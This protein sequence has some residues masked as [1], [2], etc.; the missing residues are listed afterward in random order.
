VALVTETEDGTLRFEHKATLVTRWGGCGCL[1]VSLLMALFVPIFWLAGR[2][3]TLHC[4]RATASCTV[5]NRAEGRRPSEAQTDVTFPISAFKG[6]KSSRYHYANRSSSGDRR[7]VELT[8]EGQ[9]GDK[10]TLCDEPDEPA[11]A[12]TQRSV[13]VALVA[14]LADPKAAPVVDVRCEVERVDFRYKVVSTIV[15]ILLLLTAMAV[16]TVPRRVEVILDQSTRRLRYLVR[17]IAL[18]R[19]FREV[20]FDEIA[21]VELATGKTGRTRALTLVM[22][23]GEHWAL[24]SAAIGTIVDGDLEICKSQIDDYLATSSG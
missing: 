23:N 8:V 1:G 24:A 5:E 20:S 3:A 18:P 17:R 15:G 4:D 10:L 2:A 14:F 7:A 6:V 9:P 21:E 11:V 13:Q 16:A 22:K 19:E 12:A